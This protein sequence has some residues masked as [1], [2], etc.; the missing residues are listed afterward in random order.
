METARL[1]VEIA[2]LADVHTGGHA[3]HPG[4]VYHGLIVG[5]VT[6]A[7][8]LLW[9]LVTNKILEPDTLAEMMRRRALP[10]YRSALHPDPAYGLGLM[11]SANDPKLHPLGHSGEGPGSKI[12][13]YAKGARAVSVWT[14]LPSRV[15]AEVHAFQL[16]HI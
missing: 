7:V 15:D 6:D 2:D 14:P 5:T 3:Y 11:L 4:W 8:R 13:V 16:L 10:E 9:L 12:A 1:A